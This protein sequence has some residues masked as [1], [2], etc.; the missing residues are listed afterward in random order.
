[1][2]N[3]PSQFSISKMP[4][5]ISEEI[6]RYFDNFLDMDLRSHRRQP[7]GLLN[8]RLVSREFDRM[9]V[10]LYLGKYLVVSLQ[11]T[12]YTKTILKEFQVKTKLAS[13]VKYVYI[14][15][16]QGSNTMF[17]TANISSL[18]S[19]AENVEVLSISNATFSLPERGNCV[20]S[21]ISLHDPM[22]SKLTT[23]L[24]TNIMGIK[25]QLFTR[26]KAPVHLV[27]IDCERSLGDTIEDRKD[28][29]LHL[30]KLH[31]E[32]DS[33]DLVDAMLKKNFID[34]SIIQTLYIDLGWE[35]DTSFIYRT[36]VNYNR[37]NGEE[38]SNLES[39][40]MESIEFPQEIIDFWTIMNKLNH[41]MKTIKIITHIDAI[42]DPQ[43][44]SSLYNG[45]RQ[46]EDSERPSSIDK[47][48]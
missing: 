33:P 29:K 1:M 6:F 30:T 42:S 34:I 12:D 2:S 14:Q 9:V 31:I 35:S 21:L 22:I 37:V 16:E 43:S 36:N 32:C 44:H 13:T 45:I 47:S 20:P 4:E 41:P 24:S 27:L 23:L 8:L 11:H 19:L 28:N 18:F 39:T 10:G 17:L 26:L 3:T 7:N 48:D 46:V 25:L 15:S 38:H 40:T 5:D